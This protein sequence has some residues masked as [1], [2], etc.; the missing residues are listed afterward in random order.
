[1]F[2]SHRVH[3]V[4]LTTRTA[5]SPRNSRLAAVAVAGHASRNGRTHLT[6]SMVLPALSDACPTLEL[7]CGRAHL[8]MR[9]R[10]LQLLVRRPLLPLK[11]LPELFHAKTGI[12][13]DTAHRV[14]VDWIVARDG[15]DAAT[16][17]HDDVLALP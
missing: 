15:H 2:I 9:G 3:I 17:G 4:S 16:V 10:Q 14:S 13:G 11:E 7:S 1:M 12:L 6:L 5:K 8:A